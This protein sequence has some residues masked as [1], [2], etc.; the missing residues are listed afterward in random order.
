MFQLPSYTSQ[1]PCD[2]SHPNAPH[3]SACCSHQPRVR[4][5]LGVSTYS[6][7]Y[8]E[9]RKI[10]PFLLISPLDKLPAHHW[11]FAHLVGPGSTSDSS[12]AGT[13]S[14]SFDSQRYYACIF[15]AAGK[16]SKAKSEDSHNGNAKSTSKAS[17]S[18]TKG[19]AATSKTT[20]RPRQQLYPAGEVT[21]LVGVGLG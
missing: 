10:S 13:I 5:L 20:L 16:I 9:N 8:S 17:N 11:W 1:F 18:T 21:I 6:R 14:G 12:I 19:G 15:H 4:E 3:S 7:R 2:T